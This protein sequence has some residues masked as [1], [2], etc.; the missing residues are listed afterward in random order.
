MTHSFLMEAGTWQLQGNSIANN[1]VLRAI[2]G[3]TVITWK[4]DNWFSVKSTLDF[5][6]ST[7]ESTAQLKSSV[8]G[9]KRPDAATT[10]SIAI[11]YRG[12]LDNKLQRYTYVL[13]HS[14]FGDVEGE[15][16]ICPNS[17]IQRYWVLGDRQKRNGFETFYRLN[18]DTY[19]FSGGIL[20][21]QYLNS[22]M[23]ATLER[24]I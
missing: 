11:K 6:E 4:Q 19:Y 3:K 16:W 2:E 23:E 21:G 24:L 22:T 17:I 13:Q 1:G 5:V 10:S 20:A 15:G 7:D 8:I 9:T 12:H 18:E 14:L